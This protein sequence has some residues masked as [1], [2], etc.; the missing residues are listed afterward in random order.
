M[1][2]ITHEIQIAINNWQQEI[3]EDEWYFSNLRQILDKNISDGRESY[4]SIEPVFDI[5]INETNSFLRAELL[6]I[7]LLLVRKSQTTE[8]PRRLTKLVNKLRSQSIEMGED[9]E[10]QIASIA[11]H[12]R[13]E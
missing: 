10:Q 1:F 11:R 3:L 5:L 13:I 6:E 8:Q 9:L 7:I 12:Y 4:Q 2:K